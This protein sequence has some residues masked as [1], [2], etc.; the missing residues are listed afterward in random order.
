MTWLAGR[1]VI[2]CY[3]V[4]FIWPLDDNLIQMS[5]IC[6]HVTVFIFKQL[7][8]L[9]STVVEDCCR[10]HLAPKCVR[11]KYLSSPRLALVGMT[12]H[13]VSSVLSSWSLV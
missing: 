12:N 13:V 8:L 5:Y 3:K 9:H 2:V 1:D 11:A 6:S 10:D 4:L 7:P